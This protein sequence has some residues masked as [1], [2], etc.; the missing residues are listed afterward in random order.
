MI[1][2][3]NEIF[4]PGDKLFVIGYLS[5]TKIVRCP[6]CKGK[7]SIV[8]EK[9]K[10]DCPEPAC[11]NGRISTEEVTEW[12]I[13]PSKLTGDFRILTDVRIRGDEKK[14]F[15]EVIYFFSGN[16]FKS[17]QVFA[18]KKE[19]IEA[20]CKLNKKLMIDSIKSEEKVQNE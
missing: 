14:P 13:I 11:H 16:G 17:D 3:Y 8:I 12:Q 6:I 20:C 1:K 5:Q 9:K 19:A 7:G 10:F 2:S 15:K 4:K 18:T